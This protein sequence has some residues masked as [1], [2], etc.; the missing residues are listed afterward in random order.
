MVSGLAGGGIALIF[1]NAGA[2]W[3]KSKTAIEA[4]GVFGGQGS[5]L[6]RSLS[7]SH[8]HTYTHTHTHTH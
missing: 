8:T 2:A 5:V 3:A 1:F 4:E 6:S 7:L